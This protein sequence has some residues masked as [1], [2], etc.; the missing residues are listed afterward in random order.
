MVQF[1]S[2]FWPLLVAVFGG[3]AVVTAAVCLVIARA[4]AP[5]LSFRA[6]RAPAG[7]QRPHHGF[8]LTRHAHA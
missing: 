7:G 8:H 1:S 6:H 3:A 5:H 4:P 2:D